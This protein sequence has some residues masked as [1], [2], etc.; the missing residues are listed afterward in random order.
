MLG[1]ESDEVVA[2]QLGRAAGVVTQ[3]RVRLK[4]FNS[5]PS[6]ARNPMLRRRYI[7]AMINMNYNQNRHLLI[8]DDNHS[9]HD[10]F[11]KILKPQIANGGALDATEGALFDGQTNSFGTHGF[12]IDSAFQGQARREW[13]TSRKA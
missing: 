2:K 1:K 5:F 10:D 12:E 9:I 6:E 11:R 4:I 8:I 3:K 13:P 7:R